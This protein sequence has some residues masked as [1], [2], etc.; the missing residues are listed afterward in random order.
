[1][2]KN[3]SAKNAKQVRNNNWYVVIASL[4][5]G[6]MVYSNPVYKTADLQDGWKFIQ[7]NYTRNVPAYVKSYDE[8]IKNGISP[9]VLATFQNPR[10][11]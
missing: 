10:I 11:Y 5:N 2:K 6:K 9:E 8:L 1:M 7:N 3:I 4:V